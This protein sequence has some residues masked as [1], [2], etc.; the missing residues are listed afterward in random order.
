MLYLG[1][2]ILISF[3]LFIATTKLLEL[4]PHVFTQS[5]VIVLGHVRQNPGQGVT[6]MADNVRVSEA[7]RVPDLSTAT[8]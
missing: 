7:G 6:K 3:I 8:R 5:V 4:F 1:Q 2:L